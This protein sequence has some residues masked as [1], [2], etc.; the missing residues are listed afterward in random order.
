MTSLSVNFSSL[1][2]FSKY[3]NFLVSISISFLSPVFLL[4]LLLILLISLLFTPVLSF[5]LFSL[6]PLLI[7]V[8]SFSSSFKLINKDCIA[9][10]FCSI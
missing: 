2:F 8:I 9:I 5:I 4:S 10:S 3:L 1:N 6:L 7:S